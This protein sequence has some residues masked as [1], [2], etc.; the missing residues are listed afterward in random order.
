MD[1]RVLAATIIEAERRLPFDVFF[2]EIKSERG[3]F[4]TLEIFVG[5]RRFEI[6]ILLLDLDA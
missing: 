2:K 3:C 5:E 1:S 6:E 4:S